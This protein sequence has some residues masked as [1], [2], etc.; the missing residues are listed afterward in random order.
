MGPALTNGFRHWHVLISPRAVKGERTDLLF[1][2]PPVGMYVREDGALHLTVPLRSYKAEASAEFVDCLLRQQVEEARTKL[3]S[4]RG[5]P[6]V[7]TR[8][9][10]TA[11]EWLK[12]HQRGT[13]RIGLIATSGAR[14]LRPYGLD[15]RA[16]L[17]VENWFLNASTDVRSSYY[18]ETPATEF[19]IQGL[20][21]DW[22]GLCWDTDFAPGERGWEV[23]AFKGTSWL[24][25][26]DQTRRQY[27]VN[28]Y[29]V[30][31]TRAREGMII[32]VPKGDPDDLTRPPSKYDSI[33][34]YLRS[35]GLPEI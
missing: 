14:R 27:V 3:A 8:E 10:Q 33:A 5:F 34:A 20:E 12:Q 2:N 16:E 25:V 26:H 6:I 17:E 28:K 21:L 31:L 32:W 23:R 13:R 7:V 30:L 29:R 15:V 11:R 4:C 9:L 1:E 24:A 19:G 35:C 22:T 18:L